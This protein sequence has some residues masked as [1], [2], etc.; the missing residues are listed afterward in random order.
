MWM[1]NPVYLCRKHLLGEHVETHMY[2]GCL[3]QNK[4]LDGYVDKGL[5]EFKSLKLRHDE[6]M[7]ELLRRG[8]DHHSP[9]ERLIEDNQ[10]SKVINSKVDRI[11][12]MNDLFLR[13]QDCK[14]LWDEINGRK[15]LT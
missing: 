13:C 2:F 3:A 6:L 10:T 5:F 15:K 7:N 14:K 8:Y 12:S 11:K 1:I 9:M 4:S